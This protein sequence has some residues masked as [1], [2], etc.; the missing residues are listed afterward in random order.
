MTPM[1]EQVDAAVRFGRRELLFELLLLLLQLPLEL[2]EAAPLREN[3]C[4]V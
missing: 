1:R 2:L 4:C 3:L